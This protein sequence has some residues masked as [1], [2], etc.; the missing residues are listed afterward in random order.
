MKGCPRRIGQPFFS[1]CRS[2]VYPEVPFSPG[3]KTIQRAPFRDVGVIR[4]CGVFPDRR[5]SCP[6]RLQ[7]GASSARRSGGSGSSKP[8]GGSLPR[9]SAALRERAPQAA[10]RLIELDESD[11]RDRERSFSVWS[12]DRCTLDF[13]FAMPAIRRHALVRHTCRFRLRMTFCIFRLSRESD[14]ACVLC[15]MI[16]ELHVNRRS[17]RTLPAPHKGGYIERTNCSQSSSE[18]PESLRILPKS[19]KSGASPC[20]SRRLNLRTASWNL[21]V[22][23]FWANS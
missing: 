21:S 11:K 18:T 7:G 13:V 2:G 3:R 20:S 22:P 6:G 19:S 14:K 23:I 1:Y 5:L 12:L 4:V 17:S 9:R 8:M 15:N 10:A 16:S